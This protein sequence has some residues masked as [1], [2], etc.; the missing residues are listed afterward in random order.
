M[1]LWL[2]I[3]DGTAVEHHKERKALVVYLWRNHSD[4]QERV[5]PVPGI[6]VVKEGAHCAR[7]HLNIIFKEGTHK[8][9]VCNQSWNRKDMFAITVATVRNALMVSSHLG[10]KQFLLLAI[11]R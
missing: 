6:G 7:V 9:N 5:P 2:W 3:G 11:F 1:S 10:V 4:L 8:H